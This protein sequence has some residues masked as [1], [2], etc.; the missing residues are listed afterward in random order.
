MISSHIATS[1]EVSPTHARAKGAGKGKVASR[2][3]TYSDG[4][5]APKR[6]DLSLFHI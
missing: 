2:F 4:T 6:A 5:G 3:A 1:S